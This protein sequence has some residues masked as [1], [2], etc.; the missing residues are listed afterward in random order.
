[1]NND[2]LSY[3]RVLNLEGNYIEYW[4]EVNKLGQLP[5]YFSIG[6]HLIFVINNLIF[7][8]QLRATVTVRLWFK[9][10]SG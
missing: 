5:K 3:L 8:T 7:Y 1:M 4:E 10:H 6:K 9:E 2:T